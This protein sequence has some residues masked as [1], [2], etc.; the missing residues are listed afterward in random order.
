MLGKE[1]GSL[2]GRNRAQGDLGLSCGQDGGEI[3]GNAM[4]ALRC[5]WKKYC[6]CSVSCI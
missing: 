1:E 2:A 4:I 3:P 6:I 5:W